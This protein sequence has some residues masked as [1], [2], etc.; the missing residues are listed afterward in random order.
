MSDLTLELAKQL[1]A[2]PSIT[3]Q[4]AGCQEL[5]GARLRRLNFSIERF[6]YQGVSNL[7]ARYGSEGPLLVFA[8]HTDVVPAGPEQAWT[9]P[10]FEPTEHAGF[11]WGRGAADMKGSLAAMLTAVEA[12]LTVPEP[13]QGSIA[14]L[15]TSA[16]E[17]PGELG[18]P[19]VLE[20]LAARNET[21]SWCIIGEP[22]SQHVVGDM[23]KVGRRGSLTGKLSIIG[24]QGHVAYPHL[25]DNPI[26]LACPA[27][28]ELSKIVWDKGNAHFQPTSLQMVNIAA[29]TGASNV[30]PGELT[31][32][33]NLRYS[34]MLTAEKIQQ[35]I[36]H[37]LDRHGLTYRMEWHHSGMPFYCPPADLVQACQQAIAAVVGIRPELSTS[38]G[39]SDGRFIAAT[40]CQLLELGLCNDTIHQ[41]DEKIKISDLTSLHQIYLAILKRL[42]C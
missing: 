26:H 28:Y 13:K 17:G 9:F 33:F 24:K 14:F 25:A 7:W 8:G 32:Q 4:D 22:T 15:I 40:G 27:L 16:E 36:H 1:I 2:L 30:I 42:L 34:P 20:Q 39:T 35:T 29:G 3:P 10:P 11:L 18:T 41:I 31:L 37:L 21:I 23:I 6:D 5:I 38:G 19:I 12:F